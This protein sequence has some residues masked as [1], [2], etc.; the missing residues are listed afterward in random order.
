[1]EIWG[2]TL[3]T[4]NS[5][6]H[7]HLLTMLNCAQPTK[8]TSAGAPLNKIPLHCQQL[9]CLTDQKPAIQQGA[10]AAKTTEKQ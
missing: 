10:D 3:T 7:L 1:M 6:L 9:F 4:G 5:L 8:A 2:K